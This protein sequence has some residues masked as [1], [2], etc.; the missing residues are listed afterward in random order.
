MQ[1]CARRVQRFS[2]KTNADVFDDLLYR[3]AGH[4][5]FLERMCDSSRLRYSVG[6]S[7]AGIQSQVLLAVRRPLPTP[8]TA[9][10]GLRTGVLGQIG[11]RFDCV[12]ISLAACVGSQTGQSA[13]STKRCRQ[14]GLIG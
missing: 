14:D 2:A 3:A 8:L 13:P 12:S 5:S 7:A 9:S 4:P 11:F 6:T 1:R 10:T